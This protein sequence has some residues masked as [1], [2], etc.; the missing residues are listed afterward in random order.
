MVEEDK[1]EDGYVDNGNNND[2]GDGSVVKEKEED[3]N[4][5]GEEGGY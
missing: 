3:E 2:V 5:Y 4:E 1:E